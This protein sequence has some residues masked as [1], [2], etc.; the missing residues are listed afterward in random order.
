MEQSSRTEVRYA[1]FWV[2]AVASL[3]DSIIL[4]LIVGPIIYKVYGTEY[5]EME[6]MIAGPADFLLTWI[7]PAVAITVFWIY[8]SATP[9]KM[10][11]KLRIVDESSGRDATP[12]QCIIR[13]VGYYVSMLPLFL[14]FLWVLWDDK[15]QGWHDKL[16]RTV[17]VRAD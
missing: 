17:V 6:G 7:F 14:G 12:G 2:R 8:K 16:A 11:F 3:I 1:G 5:L 9:G 10:A 15:K 4:G 13:Y